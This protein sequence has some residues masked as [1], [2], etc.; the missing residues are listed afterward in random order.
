MSEQS[1]PNITKQQIQAA[2]QRLYEL[3]NAHPFAQ[4]SLWRA[5]EIV[6]LGYIRKAVEAFKAAGLAVEGIPQ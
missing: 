4:R 6:Q 5:P 1:P 2:A 3:D